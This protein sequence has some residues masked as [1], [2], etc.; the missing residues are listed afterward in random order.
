MCS[1]TFPSPHHSLLPS[2]TEADPRL[3]FVIRLT[4]LFSYRQ[5][6]S[7]LFTHLCDLPGPSTRLFLKIG[8]TFAL[9]THI[10]GC[11]YICGAYVSCELLLSTKKLKDNS[12]E[13]NE[14][15]MGKFKTTT[16]ESF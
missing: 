15:I 11:R 10:L 7:A 8:C 16:G 5:P 4:L 2:N 14:T 3:P 1:L 9:I 12:E 13:R 6:S